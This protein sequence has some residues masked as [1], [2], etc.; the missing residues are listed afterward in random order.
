M[1][2]TLIVLGVIAAVALVSGAVFAYGKSWSG[3]GCRGFGNGP[4]MRSLDLTEDQQKKM[5]SLSQEFR[6]KMFDS[7]NDPSKFST[8][9]D[10]HRKAVESVLTDEQKAKLNSFRNSP[11]GY[12]YGRCGRDRW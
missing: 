8:L 7:R 5:F 3:F 10:E 2:K 6:Q 4:M 12:G 1:K 9:R 11:R